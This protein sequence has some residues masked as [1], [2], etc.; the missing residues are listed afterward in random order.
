MRKSNLN[1]MVVVLAMF[2]FTF[3]ASSCSANDSGETQEVEKQE[4]HTSMGEDAH[5]HSAG[6]Q[7]EESSMNV[8][9]EEA[10]TLVNAYLKIKQALVGTDAA[11]ASAAAKKLLEE[12]KGIKGGEAFADFRSRIEKIANSRD[13]ATQRSL[14]A[15]LSDPV[16]NLA[17]N[18]DMGMTLYK[19]YCP[20]AMDHEG[21]YWLSENEQIFN[22]YFGDK[23]LH[24][25]S[26]KEVIAEK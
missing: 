21:A 1:L 26:V 14:F 17:R 19:Q 15:G 2:S 18:H 6:E 8:S 13:I 7:H 24:C 9:D 11:A 10:K 22:P 16:A 25:G 20:M 4:S 23:M 12:T 3:I 5:M